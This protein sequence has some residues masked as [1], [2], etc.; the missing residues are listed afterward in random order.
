MHGSKCLHLVIA[1]AS[2]AVACDTLAAEAGRTANP[3]ID[4]G[5]MSALERMGAY[6]RSIKAFE[7]TAD[8]TRD[9]VLETGQVIQLDSHVTLIARMPNRARIEVTSPMQQRVYFYDGKRFTI[10]GAIVNYYA[11]VPAPTTIGELATELRDKYDLEMPLVDLFFWGTPRATTQ[12]VRSAIDV[13]P[14]VVD[15]ITCE[16]YALRQAGLD[17]QVWIQQGD[18]PLPLKVVSSTLTD[19]ARPQYSAVYTWDLAPSFNEAT[20]EFR[21]PQGA[22]K[23]AFVPAA[24]AVARGNKQRRLR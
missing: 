2:L 13:G 5:A 19:E 20:F 11:T 23:I 8:T 24:D 10:W 6:L 4:A 15:G 1:V 14:S 7:V 18:Y 12:E 17:W 9:N 16:Q 3:N 22:Q 21:P